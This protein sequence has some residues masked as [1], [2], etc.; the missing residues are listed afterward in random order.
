M[1]IKPLKGS[2]ILVLLFIIACISPI[3]ASLKAETYTASAEMR[4]FYFISEEPATLTIRTFAQQYGIDSMLWVY[5]EQDNVITANDDY[6]GLDSYVSFEMIPSQQYR[7]RAGVCCGNPVAW[8]G[9]SYIIEP[10]LVASNSPET[11]TTT[12]TLA[13]YLNSPQNLSVASSNQNEVY[14]TWDAPEVSNAQVERYAVFFSND[15]WSSGWAIPTTLT[16]VT[17]E[18]LEPDTEYQFR[19]RAD[20]DTLPVY[21]G[22]SNEVATSTSPVP[23]TTTSTTTTTTTTSTTTTTQAPQSTTTTTTT[24][25]PV[26]TTTTEAPMIEAL[27]PP[28]TT[29]T[30]TI[31]PTTTTTTIAPTTTTTTAAPITTT[32]VPIT[33]TTLIIPPIEQ[34]KVPAPPASEIS[35][36]ETVEALSELIGTVNLKE[37]KPDQA[38]ALVTN[39]AFLELPTE[40]LSAVFESIPVSELTPQQEEQLVTA[41]TAAPDSVKDT[42]EG[43]VDIYGSGLDDYVPVGSAVDVGS[44]RTLIAAS[45]AL[46]AVTVAGSGT[47]GGSGGSGS[48]GGSGGNNPT[49]DNNTST[50]KED[51]DPDGEEE[52][53]EIEGPEDQ[54]ENHFTKNSIFKYGEETMKKKFSPWGLIKKFSKETAALAF[55]ISGSV[56]VFSTLSGETR[57]ITIIATGC[58]FA[59]H[60]IQAMLKNDEE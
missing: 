58:A 5:D 45:T 53:T 31:A 41:L 25:A 23:T 34:E 26:P 10:S 35:K 57:R 4:D 32:T 15:N 12:T 44:R 13:P 18:N 28:T 48:N 36:I 21:S 40:K 6:F 9:E 59:V 50:R 14:L 24:Q 19:V 42:F 38:V 33:T 16:S 56:V 49:G 11:T 51:E 8:Y 7:L 55:T 2:W 3:S 46:T 29:T 54:E 30:T 47:T 20:N 27:I 37:I 52:D 39:T 17:V 43:S 1:K 22:W 60:Y